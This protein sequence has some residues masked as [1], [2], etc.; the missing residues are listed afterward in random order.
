MENDNLN[1]E[2]RDC[3]VLFEYPLAKSMGHDE[4]ADVFSNS[5]RCFLVSWIINRMNLVSGGSL[6]N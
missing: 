1:S 6:Q 2:L 4:L 3:I 5:N